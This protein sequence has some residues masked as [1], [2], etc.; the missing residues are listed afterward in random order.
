MVQHFTQG[1]MG[2]ITMDEKFQQERKTDRRA[3][4]GRRA[5]REDVHLTGK[6]IIHSPIGVL[7]Q[8]VDHRSGNERRK[9]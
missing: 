1:P 8:G 9:G 4:I 5:G 2:T 6:W 7:G 3:K